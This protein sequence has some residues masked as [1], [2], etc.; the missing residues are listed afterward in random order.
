MCVSKLKPESQVKYPE[1]NSR[2]VTMGLRVSCSSP[3]ALLGA[4]PPYPNTLRMDFLGIIIIMIILKTTAM[5][6]FSFVEMVV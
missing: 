6:R 2:S 4:Q 1:S 5:P 3:T